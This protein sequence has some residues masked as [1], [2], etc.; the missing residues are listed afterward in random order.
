MV[1]AQ[2]KLTTTPR[3]RSVPLW[4]AR[5]AAALQQAAKHPPVD[6]CRSLRRQTKF[7]APVSAL[8]DVCPRGTFIRDRPLT[9]FA[10]YSL[11]P[12]PPPPPLP[13]TSTTLLLLTLSS[14]AKEEQGGGARRSKEEQQQ[15]R[16]QQRRRRR[17]RRGGCAARVPQARHPRALGRPHARTVQPAVCRSAYYVFPDSLRGG[18]WQPRQHSPTG[19]PPSLPTATGGGGGGLRRLC[20]KPF[21]AAA[22]R[23]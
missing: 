16:R 21:T 4:A 11:L 8:L 12:P 5:T 15:R 17:P 2:P 20:R 1:L 7:E 3:Q 13:S 6:G 10:W 18:G 23:L 19:G 22:P 14:R 9:H